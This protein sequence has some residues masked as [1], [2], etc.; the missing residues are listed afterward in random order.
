MGDTE[1]A[2]TDT[3]PNFSECIDFV[4]E[5]AM[6]EA[7]TFP[8]SPEDL[9]LKTKTFLLKAAQGEYDATQFAEN[10]E[11]TGP[12][13][14]PLG[15]EELL[16]ALASFDL[17]EAIPNLSGN[18]HH[19]RVDPFDPSRV[20]FT[21]FATG[22]HTG[23]L[24]GRIEATG[25]EIRS[26]PQQCSLIF[27]EE[28]KIL[29]YTIGYVMDRRVGNTGGL[30]GVFGI[31]YGVGSPLPFPEANPWKKSKRYRFFNLIGRVAQMLSKK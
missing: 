4:D 25:K 31:F 11:F 19:F 13:V 17:K 23:K 22:T 30:G 10:F 1:M 21:S 6:L 16:T 9:V 20:W 14:G 29:Q 7:S 24:A 12:V 8:I 15:K 26:P 18:F 3:E 27:N 2:G 28:G 5:A